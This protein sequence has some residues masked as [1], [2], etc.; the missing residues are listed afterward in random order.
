LLAPPSQLALAST[1]VV[2]PPITTRATSADAIKGSDAALKYLRCVQTTVHRSAE[3]L[4]T[5]Q[6]AFAF[7][8]SR[9]RDMSLH[10]PL[11][12]PSSRRG[13]DIEQLS[14]VAANAKSLWRCAEDFWHVVGWAFNCSVKHKKRW[15][16]WKLW[17][18]VMLSFIE[19]EWDGCTKNGDRLEDTLIWQYI[20]SQEPLAGNTR[21][22]IL[23]AIYASG[24]PHSLREFVQVWDKETEAPKS[25]DTK[26]D[27]GPVDFETGDMGFYAS[28]DEDVAMQDAP[29][30]AVRGRNAKNTPKVSDTCL[31]PLEEAFIGDYDAAVQRLG[32][33]D[34]VNLRQRLVTLV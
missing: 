24:D 19:A 12:T 32:G 10:S 21:K 18:D 11:N 5:F 30:S 23:R 17:L 7:I 8:D 16:R 28:E 20:C 4:K 34:A 15:G 29:R 1:L 3:T 22:R 2:Y 31:P 14:D 33:M 25:K 6:T 27:V 13:H 9:R 26:K